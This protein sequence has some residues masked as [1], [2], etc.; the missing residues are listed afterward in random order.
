[1]AIVGNRLKRLDWIGSITIVLI[2]VDLTSRILAQQYTQP[3][4][5]DSLVT[6]AVGFWFAKN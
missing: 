5:F 1:M 2:A 4:F 3:V 6:L